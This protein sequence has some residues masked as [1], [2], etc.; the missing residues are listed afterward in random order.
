MKSRFYLHLIE[1]I[2]KIVW[3]VVFKNRENSSFQTSSTWLSLVQQRKHDCW[4]CCS[5]QSPECWG[6]WTRVTHQI[7]HRSCTRGPT[8]CRHHPLSWMI[9]TVAHGKKISLNKMTIACDL[10]APFL[11]PQTE[12]LSET[13]SSLIDLGPFSDWETLRA[14]VQ[15]IVSSYCTSSSL[16]LLVGIRRMISTWLHLRLWAILLGMKIKI[17]HGLDF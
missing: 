16:G 9:T 11:L 17:R 2:P 1:L 15:F 6:T 7:T 13:E 12:F 3:V 4:S 14:E 10:H 5:S 8:P